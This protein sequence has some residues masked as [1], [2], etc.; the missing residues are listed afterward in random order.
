LWLI[1]QDK[2]WRTCTTMHS[3]GKL[4]VVLLIRVF[5]HPTKLLGLNP[6]FDMNVAYC[7]WLITFS[8]KRDPCQ[9]TL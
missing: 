6:K 2:Q 1:C 7:L 8:L 5:F 3:M 9:V 4:I